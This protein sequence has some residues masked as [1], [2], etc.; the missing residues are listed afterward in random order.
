MQV[1]YNC[2]TLFYTM[3]CFIACLL[4]EYSITDVLA[5]IFIFKMFFGNLFKCWFIMNCFYLRKFVLVSVYMFQYMLISL[6]KLCEF[7]LLCVYMLQYMHTLLLYRLCKFIL[8]RV[9]TLKYVCILSTV[10][11]FCCLDRVFALVLYF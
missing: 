8:M 11:C 4:F 2:S 5:N 9:Y 7:I 3:L 10:L 1:V 6:Y